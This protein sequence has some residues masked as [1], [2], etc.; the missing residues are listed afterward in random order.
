[1]E[2]VFQ[3]KEIGARIARGGGSELGKSRKYTYRGKEP[4]DMIGEIILLPLSMNI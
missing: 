3:R 1:M 2:V 4:S